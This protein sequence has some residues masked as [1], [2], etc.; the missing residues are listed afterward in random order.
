M[1]DSRSLLEFP[2]RFPLKIMGRDQPDFETHVVDLIS[3][4]A[5]PVTTG[6][7]T[8]RTSSKG[9][10]IALTVTVSA[11]SREQLDDIYRSLSAS[12]RVIYLI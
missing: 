3:Q 4:H 2:C 9:K 6:D 5:G 8:I 11:T 7:I 10:F 12:D 1:D